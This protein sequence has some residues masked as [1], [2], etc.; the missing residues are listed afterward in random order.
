MPYPGL[1]GSKLLMARVVSICRRFEC[2][3]CSTDWRDPSAD[4]R[5]SMSLQPVSVTV[6]SEGNKCEQLDGSS[7]DFAYGEKRRSMVV[8]SCAQDFLKV[9]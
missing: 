3:L 1:L 7:A 5:V 9:G 6:K 4:L 2:S 8:L